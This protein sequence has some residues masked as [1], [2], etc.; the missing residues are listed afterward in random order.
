MAR[1]TG[2]WRLVGE[3]EVLTGSIKRDTHAYSKNARGGRS[4]YDQVCLQ[5]WFSAITGTQ[6]SYT[7]TQLT[8]YE[9][10]SPALTTPEMF[11]MP[12]LFAQISQIWQKQPFITCRDFPCWG[13]SSPDRG[14]IFA[15][16]FAASEALTSLQRHILMMNQAQGFIDS[17][18]IFSVLPQ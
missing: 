18:Q 17:L 14:E 10:T 15:W 8:Q 5:F 1:T 2:R 7:T 16:L 4:T 11:P 3:G 9:R 12:T 6:S 13:N